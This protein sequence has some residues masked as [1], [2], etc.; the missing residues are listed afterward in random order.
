MSV[1][2]LTEADISRPIDG[3]FWR[4]DPLTGAIHCIDV[5]ADFVPNYCKVNAQNNIDVPRRRV[6]PA[7]KNPIRGRTA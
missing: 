2:P 5:E 7:R 3:N 6:L 4:V 1:R